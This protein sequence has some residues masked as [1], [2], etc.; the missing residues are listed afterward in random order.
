MGIDNG[1][2]IRI[3]QMTEQSAGSGD[4]SLVFSTFVFAAHG[5]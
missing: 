3:K 1:K 5:F 2:G 4:H